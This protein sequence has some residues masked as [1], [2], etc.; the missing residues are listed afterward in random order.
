[1]NTKIEV[2]DYRQPM[3]TSLG[4]I[5]GFSLNFLANWSVSSHKQP[6]V[7]ST[8][9]WLLL[10]SFC[11]GLIL[12]VTVLFRILNPNIEPS[13]CKKYYLRTLQI[14]ISA[15]AICFTGLLLSLIV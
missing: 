6:S 10:G 13:S 3:V 7:Q 15:I 9:E 12:M 14:F 2:K 11:I 8:D 1:M 5:M 4:I